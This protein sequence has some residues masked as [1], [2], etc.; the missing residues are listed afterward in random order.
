MQQLTCPT[1][2]KLVPA[3]NV[4]IQAAIAK[5]DGCHAVFG[6]G[7]QV[8]RMGNAAAAPRPRV[9]LPPGLTVDDLGSELT[10]TR[11]WWTWT[12]LFMVF[13]C[14]FWNGIVFVFIGAGIFSGQW[15]MALFPIIH[16]TV[17]ICLAYYTLACFINTTQIKAARGMIQIAHGPLPWWGNHELQAHDVTQLFCLEQVHRGRRGSVSFTYEVIARLKSRETFTLLTGLSDPPQ[18]LFIE[19]ALENHLQIRDEYIP[20]SIR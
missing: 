17:G 12:A 14:I 4:N 19:Q 11:S 9:P 3:E 16:A 2:G 1:C 15:L 5:C 13:F 6:I 18:A 7:D 8:P 20:G 10:I